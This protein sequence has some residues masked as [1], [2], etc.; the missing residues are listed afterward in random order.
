MRKL[1]LLHLIN[2]NERALKILR[3]LFALPLLPA[4]DIEQGFN[5]I[6]TFATRENINM[7]NLFEYYQR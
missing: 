1:G 2:N 7:R 3:M 4:R 5:I 6:K